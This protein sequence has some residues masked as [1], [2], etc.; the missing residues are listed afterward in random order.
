MALTVLAASPAQRAQQLEILREQIRRV[1]A[2][3]RRYLLGLSTGL[4][5][6]DALGVWRLGGVVELHG[7]AA[8]G[9]T[10]LALKVVAA[11]GHEARLSAWVDGAGELY[12]PAALASGVLLRRLLIVRP[13]APAQLLWTAA[14]LV[15][16][17]SFA[18][19]VIDVSHTGVQLT[20]TAAKK[21]ADAARAGGALLVV[22]TGPGAAPCGLVRLQLAERAAQAPGP[23]HLAVVPPG[24]ESPT[25]PGVVRARRAFAPALELTVA[26]SREGSFGR[27][28]E[29]PRGSLQRGGVG[30][31]LR[32]RCGPLERPPEVTRVGPDVRAPGF[33]RPR[34]N[35]E[36]D[37]YGLRGSRPG[38]DAPMVDF[39]PALTRSFR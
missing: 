4:E 6:L 3:P 11:A 39:R 27:Q 12:P 15:R 17:G 22:L 13:K 28:L 31:L 35:F 24:A 5:A 25:A 29:V 2:A 8:S 20:Q 7:E 33:A 36:R 1:Q 9:R 26:K 30:P 34:K 23:R 16:S 21:L 18:C 32:E 10:S 19:V 37:G 38:R 14:Q